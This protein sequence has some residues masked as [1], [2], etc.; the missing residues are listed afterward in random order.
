MRASSSAETVARRASRAVDLPTETHEALL[1]LPDV[2]AVRGLGVLRLG[3]A[4]EERDDLPLADLVDVPDPVDFLVQ[5]PELLLRRLQARQL[6]LGCGLARLDLRFEG[7]ALRLELPGPLP[8]TGGLLPGRLRCAPRVPR[9][10]LGGGRCAPRPHECRPPPPR[11]CSPRRA[12]PLGPPFA[13]PRPC[14][15]ASR[16][17]RARR[18][19]P[20]RAR[21]PRAGPP[22]TSSAPRGWPD[23]AARREGRASS[24][25][26]VSAPDTDGRGLPG[27]SG[28]GGASPRAPA[29]RG[30]AP[31]SPGSGG[32]AAPPPCGAACSGRRPPPLRRSRDGPGGSRRAGHRSGPAP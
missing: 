17:R 23:S 11:F 19:P 4:P 3:D 27:S 22:A 28:S 25:D 12:P 21:G 26:P 31:G 5:P 6:G 13:P 15:C 30:G 7:L 10:I 1:R 2:R 18:P 9:G 16:A 14:A 20:A 32:A 8:G 29:R 24:P